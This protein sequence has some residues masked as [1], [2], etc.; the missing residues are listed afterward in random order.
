MPGIIV[1]AIASF[2]LLILSFYILLKERTASNAALSLVTLLLALI[3]FLDQLSLHLSYNPFVFKKGGVF[4]ESLLPL[5]FLFFSITYSRSR[6]AGS[7]SPGWWAIIGM[8][9]LFPVAVFLFS[10]DDFFYSPDLQ[11]EGVLFLG[12]VGYWFYM[13]LMVCCIIAL[14]NLETTFSATIGA[15]RWRMKFEV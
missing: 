2:A 4:L 3:E 10:L 6:S 9:T 12:T 11:T 8:T 13:S 7:V 5:T 14:M 15:D 1:S